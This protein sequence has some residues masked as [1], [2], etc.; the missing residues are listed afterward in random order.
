[1]AAARTFISYG[2]GLLIGGWSGYEFG[3]TRSGARI[4][5]LET[6]IRFQKVK[7]EQLKRNPTIAKEIADEEHRKDLNR[8]ENAEYNKL[9]FGEGGN[10]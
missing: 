9:F 8:L 6:E 10:L 3:R 1:M 5:E 4:W 7:I 2:L